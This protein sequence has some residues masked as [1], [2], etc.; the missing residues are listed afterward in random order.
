MIRLGVLASGSGTNAINFHQ[1]FSNHESVELA[2]IYCNNP[3]A[4]VITKGFSNDIPTQVFTRRQ[5]LNG[6][7]LEQL[8]RD[9]IDVVVLAGFL[10]LVPQNLIE[11]YPNRIIN[12]HPALLPKYGGKGMYGMNVHQ[13]VI[14]AKEKQSGITIHLVDEKY[15]TGDHLFQATA[16]IEQGETPESL[17]KKIHE[18]EYAH[19]PVVVE[20]F[21]QK[22]FKSKLGQ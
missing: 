5:L 7:L 12:I 21:V 16:D 19:F 18:L 20:E 14:E 22:E 4:G 11:G 10:W 8:K 17:A 13:A 15:D 3:V 2:K 6:E 9:H 1:Y